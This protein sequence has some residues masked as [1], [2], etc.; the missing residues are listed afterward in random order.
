MSNKDTRIKQLEKQIAET[1]ASSVTALTVKDQRI[2]ELEKQLAEASKVKSVSAEQMAALTSKSNRIE[3]LEKQL[4][5]NDHNHRMDLIKVT[6][7]TKRYL[8]TRYPILS[9]KYPN[10][11][12][13][14][15]YS[16]TSLTLLS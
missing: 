6:F 4:T 1:D 12:L 15:P 2:I 8:A 11:I 5:L 14:Q 13:S 3:E 10:S 7:R 9:R 16:I